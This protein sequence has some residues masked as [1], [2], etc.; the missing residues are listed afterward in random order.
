LKLRIIL[1][2][3]LLSS[4]AFSLCVFVYDVQAIVPEIQ[5]VVFWSSGDDVMVNVTF[6][7]TPVTAFHYVDQVGVDIGGIVS[8]YDV[9]QSSVAS[10]VQINLG[11][12][13]GNPDARV[14]VHCTVDGWS[15]WSESQTIV[16]PTSAPTSSP[17]PTPTDPNMGPTSPPD[18][19]SLLTQDQL[20]ILGVV[21]TVAVVAI[22]LLFYFK[23]R[24]R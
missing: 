10:T 15:G 19:D 23:K 13:S 9:S 16:V 8:G 21:I 14:R 6:Y 5:E 18:Q 4:A 12:I 1:L 3:F 11:E 2:C 24:K 17:E 7:H 20:V 22:G